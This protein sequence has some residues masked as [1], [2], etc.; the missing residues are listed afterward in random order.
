MDRDR[1]KFQHARF[2]E[3]ARA[4]GCDEDKASF[5]EKL[6]VIAR[7]KPKAARSATKVDG[8]RGDG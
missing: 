3:T 5:D 4:L 1:E 7:H 2:L 6:R 8:E